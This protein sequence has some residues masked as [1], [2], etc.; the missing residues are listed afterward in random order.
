MLCEHNGNEFMGR[1][2]EVEII[3]GSCPNEVNCKDDFGCICNVTYHHNLCKAKVL[4]AVDCSGR[5]PRISPG[6]TIGFQPRGWEVVKNGIT[7]ID[8][9]KPSHNFSFE[10]N[11]KSV[12][13]YMTST[14][15]LASDIGKP[16]IQVQ[17]P[18]GLSVQIA[19]KA[20]IPS[21]MESTFILQLDWKCE[22]SRDQPYEVN[23]RV[24][25]AGYDP[26]E[27]FLCKLCKNQET[28]KEAG[29]SGLKMFGDLSLIFV[30]VVALLGITYKCK[31]QRKSGS[32]APHTVPLI[33]ES[34]DEVNDGQ[35]S[36]QPSIEVPMV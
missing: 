24:P 15:G 21:A 20:S 11:Q 14:A 36:L 5:G 17:P 19:S 1:E 2:A 10:T 12:S 6:F 18:Q 16:Q 34:P 28:Q 35:D 7:Q 26:V 27:F 13:L 9:R 33:S 29:V 8:F 32:D 25:I 4:I 22:K 30:A 23:I 31:L 3:C